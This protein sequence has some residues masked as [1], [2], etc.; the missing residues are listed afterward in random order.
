M[1][2]GKVFDIHYILKNAF[3]NKKKYFLLVLIV[4]LIVGGSIG[5]VYTAKKGTANSGAK[6]QGYATDLRASLSEA[7]ALQTESVYKTYLSLRNTLD[8]VNDST[9]LSLNS[10]NGVESVLTYYVESG[11][12]TDSQVNAVESMFFDSDLATKANEK[13]NTKIDESYLKQYFAFDIKE[14][15]SSDKSDDEKNTNKVFTLTVFAKDKSQLSVLVSCATNQIDKLFNQLSKINS[16]TKYRLLGKSVTSISQSDM[17]YLKS[18]LANNLSNITTSMTNLRNTLDVDQQSYFDALVAQS[19]S[20]QKTSTKAQISIAKICIYGIVAALL[21]VIAYIIILIIAFILSDRLHS[22][23]EVDALSLSILSRVNNKDDV[24]RAINEISYYLKENKENIAVTST[25][26][27]KDIL[28]Q[29]G[30]IARNCSIDVVNQYPETNKDYDKLSTINGIILFEKVGVSHTNEIKKLV[31][32]YQA[33]HIEI[34]EVVLF[35]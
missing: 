13:L 16:N 23:Q 34:K 22:P 31:D 18:S 14:S 28:D 5:A 30:S 7:K 4:G 8:D 26:N 20:T 35:D 27:S 1:N 10:K 24:N 2:N 11:S 12:H 25:L 19:K 6:S 17:L 9:V 15:E 3:N 33:K 32:Y 21:F 29:M